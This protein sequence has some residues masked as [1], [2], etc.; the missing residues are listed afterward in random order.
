MARFVK[1]EAKPTII[2]VRMENPVSDYERAFEYNWSED[3]TE[4]GEC[5]QHRKSC[6]FSKIL[7]ARN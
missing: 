3:Q 4:W 5:L 1:D 6:F 2:Q 7:A